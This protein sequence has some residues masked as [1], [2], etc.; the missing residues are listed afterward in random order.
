LVDEFA[1][2]QGLLNQ[3]GVANLAALGGVIQYQKVKYDFKYHV[4]DFPCD[5]PVMIL[6][7]GKSI[8]KTD[9]RVPLIP[10]S[11]VLPSLTSITEKMSPELINAIRCYITLCKGLDYKV[12]ENVQLVLEQDFILMRRQDS[13]MNAEVFHHLLCLARLI[14]ISNGETTLSLNH[15][16]HAKHMHVTCIARH[17]TTNTV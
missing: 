7:E 8:I 6:S 11:S 9:C 4:Q 15:W 1:M 5:I 17:C 10:Q 3:K 13:K 2:N 14:T 16:E 12:E